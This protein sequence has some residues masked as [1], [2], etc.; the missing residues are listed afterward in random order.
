MA[1]QWQEPFVGGNVPPGDL[2][3]W[4]ADAPLS[5]DELKRAHRFLLLLAVL[6]LI[7]GVV[8]I[9]V[10]AIASVTISIFIGWLLLF[11]GVSLAVH[12]I[13][14][15][16]PARGLEALLTVVAGLYILVFPLSGT[17]TLTFVLAVWFFASGGLSIAAAARER[18]GRDRALAVFGGL[19]SIVLGVLIAVELPSSA[20]WA[21][22]LLVGINMLFWSMRAFAAAGLLRT[23][24]KAG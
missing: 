23:R 17:V 10:P 21:I 12:A 8:S 20:A 19:L 4:I 13:S 15:R 11:A 7:A 5:S 6:S 24:L 14:H 18:T 22:G 2:A 1:H 9:A 3:S 16:E